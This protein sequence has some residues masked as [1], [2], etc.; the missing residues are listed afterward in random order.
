M[1]TNL[2]SQIKIFYNN[3]SNCDFVQ[4]VYVKP[5]YVRAQTSEKL[6][7]SFFLGLSVVMVLK[8]LI[9]TKLHGNLP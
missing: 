6:M 5:G 4:M 2:N 3:S 9:T 8:M 7:I 1:H